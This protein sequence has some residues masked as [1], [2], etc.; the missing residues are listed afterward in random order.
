VRAAIP[1]LILAV[2]TSGCMRDG[3][4]EERASPPMT[5]TV[6]TV[7]PDP[8][9]AASC[10]VTLPN[11]RKAPRGNQAGM[12]HGN[13]KLWT[14]LWPDGVVFVDRDE[15]E[16]DGSLGM[17]WPWWR[18]ARGRLRLEGRRLDAI[19]R[20]L[21]ATVPG[22]YGRSGFQP[23]G[24]YFPSEGCWEITGEVGSASLTF[25]TLVVRSAD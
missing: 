14:F 18:S 17:K 16:A 5:R 11:G 10:P 15:I 3:V 9:S 25:T 1:L 21:R 6:A 7:P 8:P 4:I 2:A 24:L 12:N 13:G 22:G 20:E 23:S 19:A